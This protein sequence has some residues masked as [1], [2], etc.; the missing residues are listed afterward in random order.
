MI[1]HH[2]YHIFFILITRRYHYFV[3]HISHFDISNVQLKYLH[4]VV[5]NMKDDM[6][7]ISRR[8]KKGIL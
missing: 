5:L 6:I 8:K 1:I 7:L 4:T 2:H 3:T